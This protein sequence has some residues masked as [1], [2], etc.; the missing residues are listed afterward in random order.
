MGKSI[1]RTRVYTGIFIFFKGGAGAMVNGA[2]VNGE[3]GMGNGG[4]AGMGSG[5]NLFHRA[6]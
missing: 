5:E 3:W 4:D 2:M 6:F 1:L